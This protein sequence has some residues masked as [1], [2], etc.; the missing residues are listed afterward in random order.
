MNKLKI[1]INDEVKEC[2]VLYTFK[3][4]NTRN[5]YLICTDNTYSNDKINVYS[6]IYYPKDKSKGIE[7]ITRKEDW[8]E[9]EEFIRLMEV[10]YNACC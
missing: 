6:F 1:S 4:H 9:V 2:E 10:S 3:S 5:C 7:K 8:D